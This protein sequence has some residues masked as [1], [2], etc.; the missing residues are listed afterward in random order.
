MNTEIIISLITIFIL[1]LLSAFFSGS[2]TAMTASNQ[3]RM[4]NLERQGNRK[5][6]MVNQ[7]REKK[8]RMI[9]ALLLG[10]NLVNIASSA[11]ATSVL[12]SLLGDAG[13][14]YA[15]LIMTAVV[16]IFSEVLPKTYAI[17]HADSMAMVVVRPLR[18]LILLFTPATFLISGIVRMILR[19]F[20]ADISQVYGD[21]HTEILR[22]AIELHNE[23]TDEEVSEQR[24]MMHSILDLA[25]LDVG[26][27]MTHRR[28]VEMLDAGQPPE[29]TIEEILDSQYSRLPLWKDQPD[30]IIGVVHVK[31]VL[32]EMQIK[33]V[34]AKDVDLAGIAVEPWFVPI[35]T[36][37]F[38]QLQAFRERREHFALVVDEYGSFMGIVTLEDILEEI[39]GDIDDETDEI[40]TGVRRQPNGS[41]MI[42]GTVTVRELNREFDW[43]LP[44][45]DYSTIA[46]L[47]LFQSQRLPEVG[48]SFNFF[49]CRFD[50][51]KRQRHQITLVRVT[52]PAGHDRK[53]AA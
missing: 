13:V 25:D 5:A 16:L 32:K 22:G 49:G 48:Q 29:L 43:N 38:D 1:L 17:H 28:Q 46:G 3:P 52:P 27:V 39:V 41:Y 47:L 31:A 35:T 11:L 24:A 18:F 8:E 53:S 26:K 9:G 10:N 2:E 33:G 4:H 44:E 12:I 21:N 34:Q 36:T 51:V 6:A 14:F 30:N 19:I 42:D 40:V 20:G 37:L 7:I 50:V 15:T 45:G 23:G